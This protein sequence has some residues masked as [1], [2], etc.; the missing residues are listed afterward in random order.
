MKVSISFYQHHILLT[1][2]FL[3]QHPSTIHSSRSC[4]FMG[5]GSSQSQRRGPNPSRPSFQLRFPLPVAGL[6][7]GVDSNCGQ[8]RERIIFP[9][10]FEGHFFIFQKNLKENLSS[11]LEIAVLGNV[12]YN[13]CSYFV[14][15]GRRN[16][17]GKYLTH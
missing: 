2:H 6:Q 7:L 13:C 12:I 16:M 3:F 10:V 14:T 15:L 4:G 17:K 5:T 9:G 1:K 11:S 8:Q